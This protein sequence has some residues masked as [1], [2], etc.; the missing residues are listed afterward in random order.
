MKKPTILSLMAVA[1]L[2]GAPL[3]YAAW[4]E[5][6][7]QETD[8]PPSRETQQ[9]LTDAAEAIKNY[10]ADKR[11]E[12]AKKAQ[13]ALDALDTRIDALEKQIDKDWDKMNKAAREQARSSLKALHEQRVQVAEWYGGLKNSTASAWEDMKKGFSD[14]YKSL[15]QTWEKA[16]REYQQKD[17]KQNQK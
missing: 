14:A 4:H 8:K 1:L 15:R 3:N 5:P 16:E 2:V 9:E 13:A 17:E 11:E 6:P 7:K 12:A 10:T